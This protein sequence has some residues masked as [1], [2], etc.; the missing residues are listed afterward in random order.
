MPLTLEDQTTTEA[1]SQGFIITTTSA[2]VPSTDCYHNGISY[3]DGE[4]ID[5]DQACEHCYCMRG[6][7]VCAV[8]EC[9]PLEMHGKNCTARLPGPGECCPQVYECESDLQST[10]LA[11]VIEE[12]SATT[13]GYKGDA[14]EPILTTTRAAAAAASSSSEHLEKDAFT[15]DVAIDTYTDST[16]QRIDESENEIHD[17]DYDNMTVKPSHSNFTAP[18]KPDGVNERIEGGDSTSLLSKLDEVA[19]TTILA[20]SGPVSDEQVP[21]VLS[22]AGQSHTA[23]KDTTESEGILSNLYTTIKSIVDFTTTLSPIQE[24]SP[25]KA[26]DD[27]EFLSNVIPGEGDCLDNGVSYANNTNVPTRSVCEE[28]CLCH[29]SIVRCESVNCTPMPPNAENCKILHE[30][31][32]CCPSY[33]CESMEFN[34]GTP[35]THSAENQMMHHDEQQPQVDSTTLAQPSEDEEHTNV[36]DTK[37]DSTTIQSAQAPISS[38]LDDT[39]ETKPEATTETELAK[40]T[41]APEIESSTAAKERDEI[42]SRVEDKFEVEPAQ[43]EA[44]KEA[45]TEASPSKFE[46]ESTTLFDAGKQDEKIKQQQPESAQPTTQKAVELPQESTTTQ[47]PAQKLHDESHATE[48]ASGFDATTQAPSAQTEQE[49]TP[50]MQKVQQDTEIS[51]EAQKES[52]ISTESQEA[53]QPV[54]PDEQPQPE[55]TDSTGAPLK[56]Q[57]EEIATEKQ[58][59]ES[60]ISTEG[61]KES[62]NSTESQPGAQPAIQSQDEQITTE[63]AKTQ[64]EGEISTESQPS[65]QPELQ[66]RDAFITTEV[67]IVQK[68]EK[69][70]QTQRPEIQSQDENVAIEKSEQATEQSFTEQAAKLPS[71]EPSSFEQSAKLPE[72]SL[73]QVTERLV[74]TSEAEGTTE[75][76]IVTTERPIKLADEVSSTEKQAEE[77][78]TENMIPE[79]STDGHIEQHDEIST[80]KFFESNETIEI[81]QIT[82]A[83]PETTTK[84]VEPIPSDEGVPQSTLATES[85]LSDETQPKGEEELAQTTATPKPSVQEADA[86][87]SLPEINKVSSEHIPLESE[88]YKTEK[89]IFTAP[90]TESQPTATEQQPEIV[91]KQQVELIT[92]GIGQESLEIKPEI[93]STEHAQ[94]AKPQ[95]ASTEQAPE[96]PTTLGTSKLT[97]SGVSPNEFK[98]GEAVSQDEKQELDLTESTTTEKLAEEAPSA[99]ETAQQPQIAQQPE[100][101]EQKPEEQTEQSHEEQPQQPELS[102]SDGF[103]ESITT[104][105]PA[106][107]QALTE[108]PAIIPSQ[109]E[110]INEDPAILNENEQTATEQISKEPEPAATEKQVESTTTYVF[111]SKQED[112]EIITEHIV[113][114]K[115]E[116]L[117]IVT[118][119]EESEATTGYIYNGPSTAFPEHH[120]LDTKYG[121]YNQPP[122]ESE[123]STQAPSEEATTL[124]KVKEEQPVQPTIDEIFPEQHIPPA[125]TQKDHIEQATPSIEQSEQ[126]TFGVLTEEKSTESTEPKQEIPMPSE[127]PAS[128][129][130]LESGSQMYIANEEQPQPESPVSTEA[131][132]QEEPAA[133]TTASV[134]QAENVNRIG[135]KETVDKE[136]EPQQP[137]TESHSESLPKEE[138]T[139]KEEEEPVPNIQLATTD[140]TIVD[141]TTLLNKIHDSQATISSSVEEATT[142]KQ[143]QP[144]LP[145]A[146]EQSPQSTESP[147]QPQQQTEQ[148]LEQQSTEQP[149]Q[150]PQE[151]THEPTEQPQEKPESSSATMQHD[152][153]PEPQS[154][155]E[156][157]TTEQ[158]ALSGESELTTQSVQQAAQSDEKLEGTTST[159]IAQEHT[160]RAQKIPAEGTTHQLETETPMLFLAP[161][162][163]VQG[164][165][166]EPAQEQIST[167]APA[168]TQEQ[169]TQQEPEKVIESQELPKGEGGATTLKEETIEQQPTE[170]STPHIPIESI[171]QAEKIAPI[172]P[173]TT[174][175]GQEVIETSSTSEPVKLSE[176]GE[177]SI[178]AHDEFPAVEVTTQRD[179]SVAGQEEEQ[180]STKSS[181]LDGTT[182]KSVVELITTLHPSV[183]QEPEVTTIAQTAEQQPSS[184]LSILGEHEQP[185]YNRVDSESSS[186]VEP[187]YHTTESVAIENATSQEQTNVYASPPESANN[188]PLIREPTLNEITTKLAESFDTTTLPSNQLTS[189]H[190]ERISDSTTLKNTQT[191]ITEPTLQ[192]HSDGVETGPT[193]Q[194]QHEQDMQQPSYPSSFDG[195]YGS[196]PSQYPDEEYTDEEEPTVFGPGTCRYGGKLY[197]SAQQIPR[198]DP[199]DFCFCFRSDIICLQQS[200]PPPIN[201]CHEE[202]IQGFCCP[203]YECPVSM[204]LV[205][206]T[207][208]TTTTTLPPYL[209]HFQRNSAKVTRSGC[210]IQGITYKI[211]DR[212]TTASGPCMDCM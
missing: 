33:H 145:Q 135:E 102:P 65:G 81:E 138:E 155:D 36:I 189:S 39:F 200:C 41:S 38:K 173:E 32:L 31:G 126:T 99:T 151:P 69:P 211:G 79:S 91:E 129:P 4:N 162:I 15:T 202:P 175:Y 43:T 117:E 2:P 29:N 83:A 72:P 120:D 34:T 142:Q 5:T 85:K 176:S 23:E 71:E 115:Q 1:P 149:Q 26:H 166:D 143:E 11:T 40:E 48:Q 178:I 195:G 209:S 24:Q 107:E 55:D 37:L 182:I 19:A 196:V 68:I 47:L 183:Q 174:T 116:D 159:S 144:E 95:E 185:I 64:E 62:E 207:T 204:G 101:S 156:T 94:K 104:E 52:E 137:I 208:T 13:L 163:P 114:S 128:R 6:D 22:I 46:P 132:K 73:D 80:E 58:Q 201:G 147:E 77:N 76:Q 210:Q 139:P 92:E 125:A 25:H 118:T 184:E 123:P 168:L 44:P 164:Q 14:A 172:V 12:P 141:I 98:E 193:Q 51:T 7:I 154:I 75:S 161:I 205:L 57:D 16:S 20:D 100:I 157:A 18:Q 17:K 121:L 88:D 169:T 35:P 124:G 203:R 66:H 206:N 187:E 10:T 87:E 63:T 45:T 165:F 53:T 84:Y 93:S 133:M 42:L 136:E 106:P 21:T 171:S 60:E 134:A 113:P 198:D 27:E 30:E 197:V 70:A 86:T 49:L 190:T 90:A 111:P 150:Q 74:E 192:Q 180:S 181:I 158:P 112:L 153:K 131:A 56:Q 148:A 122:A 89:D 59:K 152:D 212:V 103:K 191:E 105:Q 170:A 186:T 3:A 179:E 127:A 194:Q 188:I 28:S 50:I 167:D 160:D 109:D 82:T 9:K 8:Q 61:Q 140:P 146:P 108:Q 97:V 177:P 54:S 110:Q 199:C 67:A 96:E 119:H 130:E 78:P